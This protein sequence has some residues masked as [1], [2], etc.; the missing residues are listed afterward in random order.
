ME[1]NEKIFSET[2]FR[3]P[4]NG[5]KF[6]CFYSIKGESRIPVEIWRH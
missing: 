3:E 2:I 1:E 6:L 5:D 4:L